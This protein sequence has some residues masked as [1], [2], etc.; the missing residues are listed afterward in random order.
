MKD[1]KIFRNVKEYSFRIYTSLIK[2]RKTKKREKGGKKKERENV[3]LFYLSVAYFYSRRVLIL[4]DENSKTGEM[5]DIE[6]TS[7]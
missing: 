4:H 3:I 6:M 2:L 7:R 1:R 5:C